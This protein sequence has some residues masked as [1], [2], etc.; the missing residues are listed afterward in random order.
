MDAIAAEGARKSDGVTV[1]L[2]S[3][4]TLTNRY[5]LCAYHENGKRFK[6]DTT[7]YIVYDSVN[8][9][10]MFIKEN[11]SAWRCDIYLPMP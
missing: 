8:N 10:G 5:V 7:N 4:S 6:N 1:K 3:P 2:W 9:G 11:N